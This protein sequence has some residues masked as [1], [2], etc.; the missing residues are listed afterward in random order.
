MSEP[1]ARVKEK[2]GMFSFQALVYLLGKAKPKVAVGSGCPAEEGVLR[3]C[4]LF[5]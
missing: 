3:S 4:L 1:S 5:L 2:F